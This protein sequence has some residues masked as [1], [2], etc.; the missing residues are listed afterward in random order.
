MMSQTEF[1]EVV[2]LRTAIEKLADTMANLANLVAQ[3][4]VKK[5]KKK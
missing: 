5:S 2:K 1:D 4:L 3:S